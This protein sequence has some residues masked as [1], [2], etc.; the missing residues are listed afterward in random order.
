[1]AAGEFDPTATH[2]VFKVTIFRAQRKQAS[3]QGHEISSAGM[4][5]IVLAV[6][7]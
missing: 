1:M 2:R 7:A 3:E 4:Q 5:G 6:K